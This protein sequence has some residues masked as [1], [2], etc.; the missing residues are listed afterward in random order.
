MSLSLDDSSPR[1]RHD[2]ADADGLAVTFPLAR[3]LQTLREK[4]SHIGRLYRERFEQVKSRWTCRLPP[5]SSLAAVL[6]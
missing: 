3:C 5:P 1:L 4:H 2:Q 6:H